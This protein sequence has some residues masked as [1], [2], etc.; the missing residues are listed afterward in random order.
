MPLVFFFFFF[1]VVSPWPMKVLA[2]FKKKNAKLSFRFN[3]VLFHKKKPR[4][5]HSSIR[6]PITF[7]LFDIH[8]ALVEIVQCSYG[9][10]M[11]DESNISSNKLINANKH[12]EKVTKNQSLLAL[13]R[14]KSFLPGHNIV[15][16]V[17][18]LT[19]L[20]FSTL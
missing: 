14:Y 15:S 16:F 10:G 19:P 2:R 8:A 7:V 17:G 4:D 3:V 5:S 18:N 13:A 20:C 9:C 12:H 1:F 6:S 11:E